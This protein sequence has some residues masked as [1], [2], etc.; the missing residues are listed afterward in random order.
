[1]RTRSSLIALIA[2]L[3]VTAAA[4]AQDRTAVPVSARPNITVTGEATVTT[5]PDRAEI[6]VA[7]V[8]QAP[9]A[10]DAAARNAERVRAVIDEIRRGI[11][12][13]ATIQTVGYSITPDYRYKEGAAPT[14]VGYTARNTV[15]VSTSN[16]AEIGPAIDAA[17]RRGAN[18]VTRLDFMLKDDAA[19]TSQA[20]E[21]AARKAR[22]K[23]DALA[24]ALGVR[25]TR[26]FQVVEAQ[27][28][29]VQPKTMFAREVAAQSAAP[30]PIEP[31]SIEVRTVVTLTVD[32]A[33]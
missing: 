8:T 4:H 26:V 25:I 12:A 11:S 14:I 3:S 32:I 15:R 19:A 27:P 13:G 2:A 17:T 18:E 7:V 28:L 10:K 5:A 23:A 33:P 22:A 16:L 30:T 21:Q 31:S 29:V 6:D 9:N 24:R 20:L 1:M